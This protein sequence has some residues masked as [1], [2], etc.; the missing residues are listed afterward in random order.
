M[1]KDVFDRQAGLEA[2][3]ED[4]ILSELA[5]MLDLAVRANLSD[6][7]AYLAC[8]RELVKHR[9]SRRKAERH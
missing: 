5:R 2:M 7:I 8:C 9:S 1:D 3:A 4:H 6:T